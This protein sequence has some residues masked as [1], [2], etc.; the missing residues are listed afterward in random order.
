MMQQTS[1]RAYS[2]IAPTLGRREKQ[3]YECIKRL[4]DATDAEIA[5]HL[6]LPINCITPRRGALVR[7]GLVMLAE[8]RY[9]KV[10]PKSWVMAWRA[11]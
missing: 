1:L 6:R 10:H 7:A 11:V 3:V 9:C 2:L 4:Y 8:K 5:E